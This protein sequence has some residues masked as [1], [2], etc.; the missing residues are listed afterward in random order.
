[1]LSTAIHDTVG[2]AL[3]GTTNRN[4]VTH[5]NITTVAVDQGAN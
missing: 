5:G 4:V 1:M 3:A 2:L